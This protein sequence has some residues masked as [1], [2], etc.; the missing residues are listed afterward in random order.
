MALRF[1]A[2][3][4]LCGCGQA[5]VKAGDGASIR[6]IGAMRTLVGR[7]RRKVGQRLRRRYQCSAGRQFRTELMKLF[8]Q[9]AKRLAALCAHRAFEHFRSDKGVAVPVATDPGTGAQERR[10]LL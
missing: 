2:I 6:L 9:M 10:Q 1:Q 5:G 8:K 4:L 7:A 3:E